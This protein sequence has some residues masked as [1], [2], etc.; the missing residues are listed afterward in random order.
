VL[1][2]GLVGLPVVFVGLTLLTGSASSASSLIFLSIVC[3]LGIGGVFWFGLCF[4][5]GYAVLTLVRVFLPPPPPADASLAARPHQALIAPYVRTRLQK[6]GD[7]GLIRVDLRRAGWRS[8]EI[9][10][11]FAEASAPGGRG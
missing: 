6:G 5:V 11:G 7:P 4:V 9:E 10:A 3:T 8:D 2:A 1:Q